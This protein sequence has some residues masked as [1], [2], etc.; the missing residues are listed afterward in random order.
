MA[1]TGNVSRM[2][3]L[4]CHLISLFV[5]LYAIMTRDSTEGNKLANHPRQPLFLFRLAHENVCY[6]RVLFKIL[7]TFYENSMSEAFEGYHVSSA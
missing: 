2:S 7:A 1:D 4:F 5:L 6:L 3:D